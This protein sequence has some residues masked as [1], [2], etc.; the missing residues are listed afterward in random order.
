MIGQVHSGVKSVTQNC[1]Y[2]AVNSLTGM[3]GGQMSLYY[4]ECFLGISFSL[5]FGGSVVFVPKRRCSRNT[6]IKSQALSQ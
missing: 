5:P 4:G 1:Y 2:I 3:L 6:Y